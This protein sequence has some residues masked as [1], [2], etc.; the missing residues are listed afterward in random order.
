MPFGE[1]DV[2]FVVIVKVGNSLPP[3]KSDEMRHPG[4]ATRD[5][6]TA[7]LLGRRIS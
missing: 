4:P 3:S 1:T 6:Q 7:E 2:Q 5:L